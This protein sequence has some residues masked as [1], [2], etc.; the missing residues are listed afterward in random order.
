MPTQQINY[1]SA[2]V[3]LME[4]PD[5]LSRMPCWNRKGIMQMGLRQH[6]P[7]ITSPRAWLNS[8]VPLWRTVTQDLTGRT[9][10][11]RYN[12]SL[13]NKCRFCVDS[14]IP[15]HYER[16]VHP[17]EKRTVNDCTAHNP[18]GKSEMKTPICSSDRVP[19]SE[20]SEWKWTFRKH[21]ARLIYEVIIVTRR[22][23]SPGSIPEL[24]SA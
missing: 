4:P 19:K 7:M 12:A 11:Y 13:N 16:V 5:F 21:K 22:R 2:A 6:V 15:Y 17:P 23:K 10:S 18:V 8:K 1:T 14:K 24:Q 20:I 3:W 9:N